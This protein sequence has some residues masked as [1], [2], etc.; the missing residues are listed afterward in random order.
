MSLEEARSA[1]TPLA[2][3]T[4][5]LDWCD[6]PR[7]EYAVEIRAIGAIGYASGPLLQ[8]AK[9]R[10]SASVM[11]KDCQELAEALAENPNL[12]RE[13]WVR[14]LEIAPHSAIRNPLLPILLVE[15]KPIIVAD[16]ELVALGSL[17]SLATATSAAGAAEEALVDI[18]CA[19]LPAEPET[20]GACFGAMPYTNLPAI[21][22]N[23]YCWDGAERWSLRSVAI[24]DAGNAVMEALEAGEHARTRDAV[25]KCVELGERLWR[26]SDHWKTYLVKGAI[27]FAPAGHSQFTYLLH[28]IVDDGYCHAE[29]EVIGW[30]NA[31]ETVWSSRPG[32]MAGRTLAPGEAPP[33][34]IAQ[35]WEQWESSDCDNS[36]ES[37]DLGC[38]LSTSPEDYRILQVSEGLGAGDG[39]AVLTGC[40]F[41]R[42]FPKAEI[43]RLAKLF[44]AD[45][46]AVKLA[47][48]PKRAICPDCEEASIELLMSGT[49]DCGYE[50]DSDED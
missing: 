41:K 50:R 15:R 33:K 40:S 43:E 26:R 2:R 36:G 20:F 12:D 30:T 18:I 25:L 31:G 5:L 34:E 11:A 38:L 37:N 49:C 23:R 14:A 46:D 22:A 28:T 3:L 47:K 44:G 21:P 24:N 16:H 6:R 35:V 8:A 17:A 19:G 13:Q 45:S 42:R 7:Q 10:L 39:C 9:D 1:S 27:P 29:Q 32:F 4:E 48:N